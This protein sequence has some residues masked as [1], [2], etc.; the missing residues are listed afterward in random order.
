MAKNTESNMRLFA[1]CLRGNR[2]DIS[3]ECVF[4]RAENQQDLW[5]DPILYYEKHTGKVPIFPHYEIELLTRV[6]GYNYTRYHTSERNQNKHF[7]VLTS[8]I[9]SLWDTGTMHEI[10]KSFYD[11]PALTYMDGSPYHE[12]GYNLAFHVPSITDAEIMFQFYVKITA[13]IIA[14]GKDFVQ[15]FKTY[16]QVYSLNNR[17]DNMEKTLDELFCRLNKKYNINIYQS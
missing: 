14:T 8:R 15:Q 5:L 9:P 4:H 2:F 3:F 12:E 10:W 7:A 1:R 11:P 16:E 13:C 17:V 6:D